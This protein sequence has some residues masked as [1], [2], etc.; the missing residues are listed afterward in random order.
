MCAANPTG[1]AMSRGLDE[2]VEKYGS[3]DV[4][5]KKLVDIVNNVPEFP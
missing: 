1:W 5:G 4:K 3:L 2:S